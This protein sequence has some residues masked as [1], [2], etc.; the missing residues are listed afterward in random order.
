MEKT[1][2]Q[3]GRRYFN[4]PRKM[5]AAMTA[6][7]WECIPHVVLTYEAEVGRLLELLKEHNASHPD[8][9]ITLNT[10][11]LKLITEGIV[12]APEMN[13]HI[14][15]RKWL[16]SGRIV[17]YPNVDISV[18][19]QF[20][21]GFMIPVT[22]RGLEKKSMREIAEAMADC[23]KRAANSNM[24]EVMYEVSIH[25]T[26]AELRRGHI[27]KAVGRLVGALIDRK[28]LRTL[29]PRER[30]AYRRIPESERLTWSDLTQ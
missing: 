29:T 19:V 30:R 17:F 24:E 15:Y 20:P 5:V 9:H 25:D 6:E 7:S 1:M 12:A 3:T 4:L 26:M 23:M 2:M 13:G 10:A 16:V 18:P 21:G 11:M 22:L 27:F 14:H 28:H 8:E